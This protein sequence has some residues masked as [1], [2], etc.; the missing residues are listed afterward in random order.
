MSRTFEYDVF[1]SYSS[2]DKKTVHALAKRLEKDG[3]RVWLDVWEIIALDRLLGKVDKLERGLEQSRTL[4]MCMSPAE[5]MKPGSSVPVTLTFDGGIS[6]M[7]DF[8]VR[9]AGG[10]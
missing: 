2:K 3:L 7:S 9:S 6:L 8:A 1:L 4:L 5:S 10:K